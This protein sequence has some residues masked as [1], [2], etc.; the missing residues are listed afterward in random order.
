V[1][2]AWLVRVL[3]IG[4]SCERKRLVLTPLLLPI[5]FARSRYFVFFNEPERKN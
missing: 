4:S 2:Q 5:G 3:L 1:D